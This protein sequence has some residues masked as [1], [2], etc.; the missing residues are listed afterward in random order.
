MAGEYC[1][2]FEYKSTNEQNYDVVSVAIEEED[3]TKR[4]WWLYK[5]ESA[6]R[7]L[8]NTW[9]QK[10]GECFISYAALAECRALNSLGISPL[11]FQW[12]DIYVS[13]RELKNHNDLFNFGW[14][15]IKKEL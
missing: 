12:I 14:V 2:D 3:G 9:K 1:I 8:K 11:A 5:D 15:K 4:N 13:W 10:R 7:N 6:K